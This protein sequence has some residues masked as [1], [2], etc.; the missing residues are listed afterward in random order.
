MNLVHAKNLVRTQERIKSLPGHA[1]LSHSR[2]PGNFFIIVN[3]EIL[4]DQKFC[5]MI[6]L[7]TGMHLT[8]PGCHRY[9]FTIPSRGGLEREQGCRPQLG[10]I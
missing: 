8:T 10:L 5:K 2:A 7:N 4:H 9:I 6:K 1:E 3:V